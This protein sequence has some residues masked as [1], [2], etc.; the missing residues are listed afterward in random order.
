VAAISL[1]RLPL[2]PALPRPDGLVDSV[3]TCV[4][5][6]LRGHQEGLLTRWFLASAPPLPPPSSRITASHLIKADVPGRRRCEARSLSL[7]LL[8]GFCAMTSVTV[9]FGTTP[10]VDRVAHSE[11]QQ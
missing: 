11:G 9:L 5:A 4:I 6:G 10:A 8:V 3:K 7:L 1:H 2:P